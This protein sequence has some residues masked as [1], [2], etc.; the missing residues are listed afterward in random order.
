MPP[1]GD[2]PVVALLQ[3]NSFPKSAFHYD[4]ETDTHVCPNGQRLLPTYAT[5]V[6]GTPLM[7]YTNY[8]ACREC[9]IR[10]RCTK[11]W[12]RGIV[13]YVN[14]AVLERMAERLA[15]RPDILNRRGESVEHPFGS[16]KQWMGAR[17]RS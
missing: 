1:A 12:H 4:N 6:R 5:K 7:C 13:R 14:E 11:S 10:E 9:A 2:A 8:Q 3:G 17:G 15:R 16:I